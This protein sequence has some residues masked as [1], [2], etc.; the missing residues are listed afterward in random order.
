MHSKA[1]DMTNSI[2][3]KASNSNELN[4]KSVK[5]GMLSGNLAKFATLRGCNLAGNWLFQVSFCGFLYARLD[6]TNQQN[7]KKIWGMK[8]KKCAIW[9]GMA[10]MYTFIVRFISNLVCAC[11]CYSPSSNFVCSSFKVW[12]IRLLLL[13]TSVYTIFFCYCVPSRQFSVY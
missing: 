7:L 1:Q 12:L 5:R 6:S 11:L 10:Q 3:K 2:N 9:R 13:S 4:H 8:G